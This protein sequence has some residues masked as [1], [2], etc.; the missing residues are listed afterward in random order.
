M[1]PE[2]TRRICETCDYWMND[3]DTPF[4][5]CRRNPPILTI[6][7]DEGDGVWGQ[8][9]TNME[10]WCGEWRDREHFTKHGGPR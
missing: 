7:P 9:P 2:T 10:D 3:P 8:P 5:I 4:G 6:L 1:K